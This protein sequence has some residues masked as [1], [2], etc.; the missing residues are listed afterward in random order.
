[1]NMATLSLLL[2][3]AITDM[4]FTWETALFGSSSTFTVHTPLE[5]TTHTQAYFTFLHLWKNTWGPTGLFGTWN[6]CVRLTEWESI[7]AVS[8]SNNQQWL[9]T[10]NNKMCAQTKMETANYQ[11]QNEKTEWHRH[12]THTH[13]TITSRVTIGLKTHGSVKPNLESTQ[14]NLYSI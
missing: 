3:V 11:R 2:A 14:I 6:V 8:P 13:P 12:R 9:R 7:V 10:R 4:N 5:M 1:M